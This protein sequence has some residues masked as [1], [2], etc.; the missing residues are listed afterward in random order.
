M[1]LHDRLFSKEHVCVGNC[2]LWRGVGLRGGLFVRL[3]DKCA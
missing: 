1:V 3:A 2:V